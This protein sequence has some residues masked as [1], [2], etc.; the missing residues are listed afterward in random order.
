M[1]NNFSIPYE[2][3]YTGQ[4]VEFTTT[5]SR[6][7]IN[8]FSKVIGDEDSFHVD[9]E[10]AKMMGFSDVIGHG[11]H[12]LALVSIVIGTK[13]PGF[14]TIYMKQEIN[15]LKPVFV[16]DEITVCVEVLEKLPK[17]RLRLKTAIY[18]KLKE[19][20]MNGEAIVKTYK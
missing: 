11:V 17:R 10:A 8:A 12:L 14:G 6:E 2:S 18:S 19:E 20:M 13:L 16:E 1:R 9:V 3:I 5:L 7:S 4:R 15:F